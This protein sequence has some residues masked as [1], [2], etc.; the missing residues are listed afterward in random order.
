M[1]AQQLEAAC[2]VMTSLALYPL[3]FEA[4]EDGVFIVATMH[5][6]AL[7]SRSRGPYTPDNLPPE[8]MAMLQR[9]S[10][11]WSIRPETPEFTVEGGGRW[12]V[13]LMH[14]PVSQVTVRFV[15][16]EDAPPIDEPAPNNVGP[17]GDIKIALRF[18][19]E[20]LRA[21]ASTVGG[22]PPVSIR[23]AH[24]PNP[25]YEEDRARM[26]ADFRHLVHSVT[27]TIELD[28]SLCGP[29]QL[30]AHDAAVK[31]HSYSQGVEPLGRNGFALWIGGAR[32]TA[33]G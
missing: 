17:V 20:T 2:E 24:P 16:P 8:V 21:A 11:K 3:I 30:R 10:L 31:S 9:I 33:L 27:P 32:V 5:E 12:P 1:R 4:G 28:R 15:V 22:E 18:V 26:P 7:R 23:L 6:N 14:L 29:E 25:R 19:A 13:L